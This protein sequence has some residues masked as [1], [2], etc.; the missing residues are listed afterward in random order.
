MA[1]VLRF[2]DKDGLVRECFFGLVHA[3]NTKAIALKDGLYLV[4][5]YNNFDAQ[6]IRGQGYDG[7]SNM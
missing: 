1:I 7:S 2:V 4:L 5:S 6:N 3:P